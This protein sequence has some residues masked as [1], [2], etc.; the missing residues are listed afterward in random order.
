MDKEQTTLR[1]DAELAER[2]N[3]MCREQK[4]TLSEVLRTVAKRIVKRYEFDE[5]GALIS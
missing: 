5:R 3:E 4:E 2:L 1:L